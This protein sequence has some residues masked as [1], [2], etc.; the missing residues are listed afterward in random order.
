ME[1]RTARPRLYRRGKGGGGSEYCCCYRCC[2]YYYYFNCYYCC[3][4]IRVFSINYLIW[5]AST[6]LL[7]AAT[8]G[9]QKAVLCSVMF[10]LLLLET[11]RVKNF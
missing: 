10:F 7:L 9:M 3:Y 8:R 2:Y 6:A 4:I 11:A 1:S 5:G